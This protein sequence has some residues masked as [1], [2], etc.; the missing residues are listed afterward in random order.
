VGRLRRHGIV[1]AFALVALPLAGCG[2]GGET[3]ELTIVGTEMAFEAPSTTPAGDDA[4]T[5]RNEGTVAHEVAF[6]DPSGEIVARRSLGAGQ[7]VE[8]EVALTPG[9]W[10]LGCFEPG[11]YEGGMHSPLAVTG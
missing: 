10:E 5:F 9:R 8:L 11:H 3:R 6:R 7:S 2:G 1:V 4:V